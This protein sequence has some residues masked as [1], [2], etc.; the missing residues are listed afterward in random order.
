MADVKKNFN[1]REKFL[2]GQNQNAILKQTAP[3]NDFKYTLSQSEGIQI[4]KY[5]GNETSVVIPEQIE[6]LPV[7]SIGYRA[8][9]NPDLRKVVIPESV[10]FIVYSAFISQ[11]PM[12]VLFKGYSI[13]MVSQS[14]LA[15]QITF[16]C[17]RSGIVLNLRGIINNNPKCNISYRAAD[18]DK[19]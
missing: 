6:N 16:Y 2:T 10:K 12:H 5:I 19:A 3:S 14:F 7:T 4:S 8:F 9:D 17:A 1:K 15:P 11:Q 18:F 13:K